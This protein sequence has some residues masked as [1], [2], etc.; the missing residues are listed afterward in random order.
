MS[1][2]QVQRQAAPS[3]QA[4]HA[5]ALPQ[6]PAAAA[7][8]VAGTPPRPAAGPSL[9]ARAHRRCCLPQHSPA[10][11]PRPQ[12]GA[13]SPR[14]APLGSPAAHQSFLLKGST[15]HGRAGRKDTPSVPGSRPQAG[16][17]AP[18][19][20]SPHCPHA[21]HRRPGGYS[22]LLLAALLALGQPAAGERQWVR[23]ERPAGPAM[24]EWGG[25]GRRAG[26]PPSPSIWQAARGPRNHQR[27]APPLRLANRPGRRVLTACSCPQPWCLCFPEPQD[28]RKEAEAGTGAGKRR[29]GP[30]AT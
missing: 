14:Y 21:R 7:A 15:L 12:Q 26:L 29:R 27:G 19:T 5:A 23:H 25:A 30:P 16:Q 28:N 3:L 22:H 6:H 18:C 17:R 20:A 8:A 24:Q 2:L 4:A 11:P 10:A 13:S 1:Y 9:P